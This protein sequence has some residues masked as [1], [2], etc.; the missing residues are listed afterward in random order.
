MIPT[1]LAYCMDTQY[2]VNGERWKAPPRS[3]H[4]LAGAAFD[5]VVVQ[6]VEGAPYV[7]QF[8]ACQHCR[9]MYHRPRVVPRVVDPAGPMVDDWAA[10]YRKSV[11][12]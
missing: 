5:R 4:A 1:D 10:R 7:T 8:V 12:R 3:R 11:K 9:A 6:R 2:D